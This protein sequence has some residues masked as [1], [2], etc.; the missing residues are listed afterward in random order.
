MIEVK[1]VSK[2]YSHHTAV[3]NLSFSVPKG[4]I[5]GFLGPNGAGKTTTMRMITGF[6]APSEGVIEVA[7]CD[8]VT[9][10]MEA[11]KKIGYLPETPPLYNEL[12]V[13]SYLDFVAR[14]KG[15]KNSRER[16]ARIDEVAESCWITDVLNKSPQKL[17]KGYRQ[18]VGLAQAIIHRPEVIVLDEPTIGLDPKQIQETRKLIKSLG[19][20]HTL[21][22]STHI[23]PEV[24]MT[25]DRVIIIN[26]GRILAE[27][28]P[29]NL[30]ARNS[31]LQQISLCVRGP[32]A[33]LEAFLSQMPALESWRF[34]HS[35]G[36][37]HSFRLHSR[38]T[39][40]Q[41]EL[42]RQVVAR[43]WGLRSLQAAGGTL[44]DVFIQ[45]VT[46]EGASA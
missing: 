18:R 7:G 36:E 5:L 25:C 1:N 3:D 2:Y 16:K 8:T 26:K 4:T 21:I 29:E 31:G 28:S 46:Q 19:G 24:Q 44:E 20:Q 35:Q 27:D 33:E 14:L 32:L 12:T 17:S 41:E 30:I 22:L 11:R 23:L 37:L 39:D 40:I 42:A 10:S 6:M 38:Q 45:L 13:K 34:E 43:D 9:Q 15:L